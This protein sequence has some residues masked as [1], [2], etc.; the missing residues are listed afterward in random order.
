MTGEFAKL[1]DLELLS[2]IHRAEQ[3]IQQRKEAGRKQRGAAAQGFKHQ[4]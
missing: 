2:L 4:C 1:T 3:E